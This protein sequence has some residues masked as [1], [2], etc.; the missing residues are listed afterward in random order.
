MS[1]FPHIFPIVSVLFYEKEVQRGIGKGNE[2]IY[3]FSSYI[4]F[5]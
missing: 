2:E 4:L 3:H 1:N 5:I